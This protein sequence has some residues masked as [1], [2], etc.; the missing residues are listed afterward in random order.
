MAGAQYLE[1]GEATSCYI[2][3]KGH[4][5]IVLDCGSGL[6]QARELVS[7]VDAADVLLTHLHYDHII[8]ML[9]WGVFRKDTKLRVF[10]RF[11]DW[12]GGE[13]LDR[14]IS[15][16]F[17]PFTPDFGQVVHVDAPGTVEL[18]D[19]VKVLLYPSCHPD[20][21]SII[22]IET[23]DGAVCAAFDNEHGDAIP[24]YM[25][26]DAAVLLYDAMYTE[27]E[28]P[29]HVGWGHSY[30]QKGCE[31]AERLGVRQL[32]IT[33]HAPFKTDEELRAVE[34]QA[35]EILPSVRFARTGDEFDLRA[36]PAT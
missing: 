6:I 12:L 29:D 14:F 24:E 11:N 18:Y 21:G 34:R 36:A 28:Y 32:V 25:G 33:H 8:G 13:T 16:P 20:N 3:K 4:Y 19:G 17:W 5:A 10:A 9:N 27:D 30:W 22:R 35:R 2:L 23:E 15:P 26:K 1:F 31:S 7:D